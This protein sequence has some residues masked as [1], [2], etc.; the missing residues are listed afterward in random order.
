MQLSNP[1]AIYWFASTYLDGIGSVAL[2]K[3]LDFFGG[4]KAFF[5]A[6]KNELQQAGCNTK[7]IESIMRPPWKVIEND[8]AWCEQN[9]C[10]FLCWAD[11]DYPALLRE[12]TGSPPVLYIQ[13]DASL[14]NQPQLA[15]VGSRHPTAIGLEIAEQFAY[16][17]AESGLVVTSGLALGIDG[18]GH[19]GALAASGK[20]IAVMGTGL[21]HIYPKTHRALADKIQANGA[22]VSELSIHQMAKAHHFPMR[23]RI[24][25]GLS[26]G[27]L[28]VEAAL[29]SGSLITARFAAEQGRDVF[30][31]PS[32]I[33]HP[34]GKGCH[35]LIR[36]GAKLVES[37]E[38]ILVELPSLRG[39]LSSDRPKPVVQKANVF[40]GLA[41]LQKQLLMQMSHE[42]MALDTLV[43]RSGLTSSEVSSMLLSLELKGC[44]GVVPGGYTCVCEKP[45]N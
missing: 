6:S 12:T 16:A 13:G 41:P 27:V 40:E 1:E 44:V 31:I 14:L 26:L 36:Q 2:R 11:N 21:R 17:L 10:Q 22:I 34:L 39:S 8:V 23:N 35:Q 32:S 7:Q 42:P 24:I 25:S 33:H 15:I 43:F 45:T 28:V 3:G 9:A 5:S 30:A 20:T 38:D 37:I 4:I 19:R 29:Q 18:A